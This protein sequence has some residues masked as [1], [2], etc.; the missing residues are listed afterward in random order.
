MQ[1]ETVTIQD[2]LRV[3]TTVVQTVQAAGAE[4][5]FLQE[6]DRIH[7]ELANALRAQFGSEK[8]VGAAPRNTKLDTTCAEILSKMKEWLKTQ[9]KY[10]E[11]I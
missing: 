9:S 4:T 7:H 10:F 3:H 5:E 8:A 11:N 2:V 1:L 6:Y